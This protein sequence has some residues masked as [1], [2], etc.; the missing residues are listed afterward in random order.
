MTRVQ[1]EPDLIRFSRRLAPCDADIA[2]TDPQGVSWEETGL[3]LVK[4]DF[5]FLHPLQY[6]IQRVF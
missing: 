4:A 3:D 5:L 6:R 2:A 1:T